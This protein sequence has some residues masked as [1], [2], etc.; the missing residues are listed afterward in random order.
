MHSLPMRFL[1]LVLLTSSI[2]VSHASAQSPV[3][4]VDVTVIPMDRERR[5]DNQTV[6]VR[7]GRIAAI[8]PAATT[9]PPAGA[10]VVDGKGKFLIPGLGDAHAHLSS[11]GGGT[12]LADRAVELYALNGITMARSMYTEPHHAAVRD[13][14]ERGALLGPRLML[15][16]PPIGG[17]N[18]ATPAAARDAVRTHKAAGH[19]TLKVMPGLTR[20]V[21]DTLVAAARGDG[22]KLAGHVPADAGLSGVLA[23][24]FESIEHLDGFIEALN[25]SPVTPQESGFFGFGAI[26]GADETR[27]ARIVADVKASGATIVPTEFEMEL[28]TSMDAGADLARRAEMRYAPAAL[29]AGWVQQKDG[30]ARAFRV[31]VERSTRYRDLR[32]RI[33]RE[34]NVAGV[35]IAAGSDAFN[36]FDVAGFGLFYE[37]ETL[38]DAGLSPYEALSAATGTVARLMRLETTA[39]QIL[40]GRSADLVLLDADPL[41]DIRNVRRQGGVML[42]GRWLPRAEIEARLA[43]IAAIP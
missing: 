39:G 3:A 19:T 20:A 36:L 13:R 16:S 33:I 11:Q 34:L 27:L 25:L 18:T 10:T 26:A 30:S 1:P 17:Q 40:V 12:A 14:V 24:G 15:V 7:D 2:A 23:A 32:R 35:P 28:F 5:L 8:G 21:F 38:V 29:V 43:A 4:F 9:R 31:T 41:G 37:L 6:I 22:V 42:R